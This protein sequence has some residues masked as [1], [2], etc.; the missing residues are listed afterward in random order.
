MQ[1]LISIFMENETFENARIGKWSRRFFAYL[2]DMLIVGILMGAFVGGSD[3]TVVSDETNSEMFAW[4]VVTSSVFFAYFTILEWLTGYTVGKRLFGLCIANASG[5]DKLTIQQILI[6]NFGKSFVMPIDAII[7]M[8]AFGDTRQ[9]A[10][11]KLAGVVTIKAKIE[12][13]PYDLD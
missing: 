8:I 4:W 11:A 7:G 6:S 9:R 5:D 10:F 3:A 13:I 12:K 2:I 1:L